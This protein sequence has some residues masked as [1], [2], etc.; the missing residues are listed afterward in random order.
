[1]E[2]AGRIRDY[3]NMSTLH[4]RPL[5]TSADTGAVSLGRGHT[6]L[7]G[8]RESLETCVLAGAYLPTTPPALFTA[9]FW[10]SS[11]RPNCDGNGFGVRPDPRSSM[12]CGQNYI[13]IVLPRL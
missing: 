2:L 12:H 1:M 4:T 5:A 11:S 3:I 9:L 8:C 6:S 7:Y 13:C 10:L